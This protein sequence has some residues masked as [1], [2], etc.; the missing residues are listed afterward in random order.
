[1]KRNTYFPIPVG[2]QI[3]WV[4]NFMTKLP[5]LATTLGL[6][7]AQ[8]AAIL[9]DCA[10]VV[11]VLQ[12]WLPGVRTWALG[13]SQAA[14]LAQTGVGASDMV[15]PTFTAPDL[16]GTVVP[17]RPGAYTRIFEFVQQI[18]SSGKCSP[19]NERILGIV[20]SEKTGPDLTTIQPVITAHI[21]GNEVLI[22]WGW[23]GHRA[24]L[25]MCELQVD[26]NDGK[27]FV[28]LADDTTPNYTDTQP[29]PATATKWTYRAIYHANDQRVGVWS[30]SVS[31]MVQA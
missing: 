3:I 16:P 22:K 20:G 30:Q 2:D 19:D 31:V 26:R 14:L 12:L 18:K 4:I 23:G 9:K 27:G 15:L 25:Q 17:S 29:F 10:W 1:M 6:T 21:L 5:G 13:T 28:M 24:Y 8:V 11:Y 7:P